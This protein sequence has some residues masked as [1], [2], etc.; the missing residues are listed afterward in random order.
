MWVDGSRLWRPLAHGII[1]QY[2]DQ[3]DCVQVDTYMLVV[4]VAARWLVSKLT[5]RSTGAHRH[6]QCFVQCGK[7]GV[8]YI[9]ISNENVCSCTIVRCRTRNRAGE[10]DMHSHGV[11]SWM[12][13]Q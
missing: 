2:V 13:M 7:I 4:P 10:S 11:G 12:H 1:D 6:T 3:P 8:E 5:A 9:I